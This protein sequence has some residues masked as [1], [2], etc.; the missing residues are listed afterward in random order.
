MG[1]EVDPDTDPWNDFQW[2]PVSEAELQAIETSYFSSKRSSSDSLPHSNKPSKC[3][4]LPNWSL[5]SDRTSSQTPSSSGAL[6]NVGPAPCLANRRTKYQAMKFVGRIDYCRTADEVERASVEL[7]DKI[8]AKN[9]LGQ[10]SLGFD[11]EWIP[12]FRRGETPRKAAVMQICMDATCCYVLHIIHSGIT[13]VLKSLLE[14]SLSI[15]V[16]I[17]ISNDAWKVANDYD[18]NVQPLMDLSGLANTKLVGPAKKWS[19]S[20]LTETIT[21]KELEKPSKIRMGNWEADSL[22]KEQLQYAATDAFASWYLYEV[23]NAMPDLNIKKET[24][25]KVHN[26]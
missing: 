3:R 7:L 5:Q 23:L 2:D 8:K 18:V 20:S 25:E 12:S 9:G 14:D 13:P 11:I 22:T 15:K 17:C 16:G 1:S 6:W 24:S 21:C 19:L 4:R 26:A 10:V